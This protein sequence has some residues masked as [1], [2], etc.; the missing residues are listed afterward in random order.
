MMLAP[1]LQLFRNTELR[2]ADGAFTLIG[3]P[4][5][6]G[7]LAMSELESRRQSLRPFMIF[8]D[9]VECTILIA[10]DEWKAAA[11]SLPEMRVESGFRLVTIDRELTWDVVG[12]LARVT[13]VLAAAGIS[14]GVLSSYS[15]DHLL[16]KVAD[17]ESARSVLNQLF[18]IPDTEV[19]NGN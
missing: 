12:F 17:F 11:I 7:I 13:Q 16:I 14:V 10:D 6:A 15:R 19:T 1:L 3:I 18:Q 2:V 8:Q 4:S 9:G 5:E